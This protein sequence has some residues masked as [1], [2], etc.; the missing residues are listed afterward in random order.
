VMAATGVPFVIENVPQ[1]PLVN[2]VYLC[3]SMFGL[4]LRR[5]RGFE[6]G[7]GFALPRLACGRH[8]RCTRNGYLPTPEAP[9]MTISG[10]KHSEAWRLKAAEVMGVPWTQTIVE[11]CE[12]IPPAYTRWIG[13][14]F[15]SRLERVA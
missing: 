4:R 6:T 8:E 14:Q 12:A 10:G 9:W 2:P 11:V 1:A 7:N 3:G 5:H 13:G 15:L